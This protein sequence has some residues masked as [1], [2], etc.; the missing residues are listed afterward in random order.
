MGK[1]SKSCSGDKLCHYLAGYKGNEVSITTKTGDIITGE[2]RSVKD[3]VVQIIE[4]GSLSPF[5]GQRL[6]FI[7]CQDIESFSVEYL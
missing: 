4:P 7:R 6:T 1:N 2:L 5:V 3:C